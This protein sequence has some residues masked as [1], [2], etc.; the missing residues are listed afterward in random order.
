VLNNLIREDEAL[1]KNN[2]KK[3]VQKQ[4]KIF[5]M[6]IRQKLIIGF[7][8]PVVCTIVV[9]I[10]GY[11]LAASGM[12]ENYEESMLKALSM[13]VEYMDFG[14]ESA[15][16]ESEQLYYD[17]DL[18]RW[19]TG[20][21]YNEWTRQE[22]VE[23]V[24]VDLNVKQKG[25]EFVTN[26]YIIPR[27]TMSIV[28]TYMDDVEIPGFYNSLEEADEAVCLENLSGN[29]VGTHN[30]IDGILSQYYSDYSADVY[31]C[32][33]IRPMTTRRACIVV[34]Y[35]SDAIAS[36]LKN[37]D[38]GEDSISAFVT[39]DGREILLKGNEVVKNDPFSFTE[40]TYYQNA[41]SET[42]AS[43]IEYVTYQNRQYLFMLSKSYE[44]GSAICAMV[45]VSQVNAGADTIKHITV[46][47][48][49]VACAIALLLGI[50]IIVGITSTIQQISGDLKKVS[51]GDLTVSVNTNRH[52]EFSLLVKSIAD[53]I[54]N[55][56]NLIVQ[57][58]KTTENVSTST[59]K[60]AEA[61]EL[62]NDSNAKI[63]TA[64]DEMDMGLNQQSSDSQ[65]CLML[66]DDLS[67]RITLAVQ[68]VRKMN[69]L[70]GDTKEIIVDGMST[71][72]D[73]TRKSADTN[74]ITR[75]V[76][77]N[78]KTLEES[79]CE[80]EKFV[81]MIN[82]IAEETNLLALNASIE[83]AR[84]GE[85]G[86]G[87]AVVA[88]SVSKLSDG[89][90]EAA[91]QIQSVMEQIRH[92]ANETVNVAATAEEIVSKQTETVQNT[93]NVFQDMNKNLESLMRQMTALED[94]IESMETHRNDTLSAIESISSVSQETAASI[95][96]VNESI[97][98]QI[99]MVG[100]LRDSSVELED[101][102]KALTEAVNAFR[103]S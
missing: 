103:I 97:K 102:A 2:T 96:V 72:D 44:N 73:L 12:A 67:Q 15:V 53:M 4:K 20:A 81:S 35:S 87:F 98:N 30:Y 10:C 41:M 95:S 33:Y 14:F 11:S 74:N 19:A 89:T 56:R 21:I 5:T 43:V 13:A 83:A 54:Q 32:S 64:V 91:N 82:G 42:A 101:K 65:D 25:N 59:Q 22:I 90:I 61:S 16:S 34:D 75:T 92:E 24:K 63:S 76:T 99:T 88:Q 29:W 18:V 69:H 50:F 37:L 39:A 31:A 60:L 80:V 77:S 47:I 68:T 8:I 93:I 62:L 100:D 85:A 84:A 38:L 36:I 40:Q 55:S 86:R 23:N 45:P 52:D 49:I 9:G 51:D 58:L 94:T 48:V 79:L 78:I 27:D 26:M 17:T 28:S 3:T 71:M 7:A 66:M 70:T 6:G 1:V 57:V 46:F